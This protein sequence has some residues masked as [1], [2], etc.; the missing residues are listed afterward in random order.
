MNTFICSGNNFMFSNHYRL[1][2]KCLLCSNYGI[3]TTKVIIA[4]R[5]LTYILQ[6]N[7][8]TLMVK[9][10]LHSKNIR[11]RLTNL[12]IYIDVYLRYG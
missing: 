11:L 6:C 10:M 1:L 3:D 2:C 4:M 7:V 12:K 9:D 8:Y 5:M